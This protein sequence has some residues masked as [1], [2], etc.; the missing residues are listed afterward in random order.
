MEIYRTGILDRWT[1]C[2]LMLLFLL[3]FA[4]GCRSFRG[5]VAEE[6]PMQA[7][8]PPTPEV[9]SSELKLPDAIKAGDVKGQATLP[10]QLRL[11]FA[12]DI[13][14]IIPSGDWD[15]QATVT[16]IE[17][18]VLAF[19]TEQGETG[20]LVYRLPKEMQLPIKLGQPI[21]IKNKIIAFEVSQ[22]Y[23]LLLTSEDNSVLASDHLLGQQPLEAK[24]LEGL[25]LR[26][27]GEQKTVLNQSK[28]DTIY[29]V[30]VSL[31]AGGQPINIPMGKSTEVKLNGKSFLLMVTESTESIPTK[32]YAGVAEGRG[33]IL[34]YVITLQANQ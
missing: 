6:A 24:P 12:L 21:S 3:N 22:G 27:L 13:A 19:R 4:S 2:L 1:G 5:Q 9:A 25:S 29:Q 7:N 20:R 16:S 18:R 15:I 32:E 26:Q 11:G 8:V 14:G 17:N 33:Y 31:S 10:D 30:P 28:F 34:E 23:A